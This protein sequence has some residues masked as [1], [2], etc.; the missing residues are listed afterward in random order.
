MLNS[1][2][3]DKFH[4]KVVKLSL[5]GGA[6]CPNRI[7]NGGCLFCTPQGAGEFTDAGSMA[8]QIERQKQ[9]LASKWPTDHAIAYFQNFT[10]TYGDVKALESMYSAIIARPDIVGLA[11]ATRA[12]CLDDDVV[13]MLKRLNEKTFLWVELGLQTIHDPTLE[14]IRRGYNHEVFHQ[15]AM[16]LRAAG[17]PVVFHMLLG[18]PFES[19]RDFDATF[20]Y[21]N[22][23]RPFGVKFHSLYIQRDSELF[24]YYLASPMTLLSE[25][26]YVDIV[27]DY[28]VALDPAIVVH[29]L[30]GDPLRTMHIAPMWVRNKLHVISAIQRAYK[31]K[32]A[33]QS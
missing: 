23:F 19:R 12:D 3:K 29:R 32:L 18:L 30:T 20:D 33:H 13:A 5:D 26:D 21:I 14:R 2:L 6:T 1:F 4:T 17:I 27:S 7:H 11:I 24:S 31:E 8:M 10:N 22:T 16:K 25:A 9:R 28:L 15:G